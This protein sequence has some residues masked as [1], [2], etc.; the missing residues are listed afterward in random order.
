MFRRFFQRGGQGQTPEPQRPDPPSADEVQRAR[1]SLQGLAKQ[2]QDDGV[3]RMVMRTGNQPLP[4]DPDEQL[5]EKDQGEH[6]EIARNALEAGDLK[7]SIYHLGLALAD[8][9][10]RAE[11][12]ALL[13][14]WI[15]AA[16]P[17]ALDLVPLND[18]QYFAT[19]LAS[20]EIMRRGNTPTHRM[21]VTPL[22]GK[23]YHAKVAV[24]ASL[25]AAQGKVKEAVSLLLQLIQVKPEIP[26]ILWL[27]RWQ[28]QPGFVDALQ[29]ERVLPVV[30]PVLQKYRGTYVFAEQGRA[31][32][33]RYLPLL[34]QTY[35]ALPLRQ[36][37]EG[38]S[39]LAFAYATLLR[40]TGAFAEA[41]EVA[42]SLPASYQ[43]CVALAM[44][45]EALGNLEA[46]VAAYQQAL[47]FQPHD[48]AVRNDLGTLRLK[49][50]KLAEA[51]AFY[52]ES[53]RLDPSD[54]YQDAFAF[55]AYLHYLQT[56]AEEWLE[57]LKPLAQSQET[58]GRFLYLLQ[59]PFIGRL[60]YPG[61]AIINLMRNIK[62]RSAAGEVSLKAGSK[63][64]FASSSLEA[65][66]AT[67]AT[68][69]MLDA[70][71]ASYEISAAETLSPDPRQPLRP[72][73]YQIWRYEG[74]TPIPAVPPPDPA[75]AESIATLAQTPYALERWYARARPLGQ[76]LGPDALMS[77]LGVMVHPP[78][79]PEGWETWDWLIA[80]QIASALTIASLE[81][82]WEGSRRKAALTSLIYGPMDWSGAAALSALAILARQDMRIHIEFDRICCDLWQFGRGSAEWPHEQAM[83]FGLIFLNAYSDE[84]KEHISAYFEQQKQRPEQ[85][86]ERLE[87]KRKEY[88]QKLREE[89]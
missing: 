86:K 19:I 83:V 59:A 37:N 35:A 21:E 47:T 68:R 51:L 39:T 61:E 64:S 50:G 62:E 22:V 82:G 55:I 57:K 27:S 85:E 7:R 28:D 43:T 4:E 45:E 17:R 6:A 89:R 66:S 69:L 23:N 41:A 54:P 25:L 2:T 52:E 30:V 70:F 81:T 71:G 34:R 32:M 24:H 73:E 29:P 15:A 13:D 84:A 58:A 8:D 33:S 88:E 20:R 80:V 65:P 79:V 53:V 56:P 11:W 42:R 38:A 1:N 9:P 12:L 63:L 16:G 67:L 46:S 75:V 87:Q 40:K 5:Y 10:A 72:V 36:M 60:P 44:A 18:E 14:R 48:V 78:A 26:Y 77:L 49:Q 31:E 74:M 76:R 3:H